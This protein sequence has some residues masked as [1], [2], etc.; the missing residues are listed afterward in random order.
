MNAKQAT[1]NINFIVRATDMNLA[2]L[3]LTTVG[4]A[5][6]IVHCLLMYF[7]E[8]ALIDYSLFILST[9]VNKVQSSPEAC[10]PGYQFPLAG[11]RL[12][13]LIF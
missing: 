2:G 8:E 13:I 11:E 10:S 12:C 6:I 5:L 9:A 4:I 3:A 7:G 1:I